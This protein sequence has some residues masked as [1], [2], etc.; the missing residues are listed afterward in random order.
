MNLPPS[1]FSIQQEI[2]TF[3]EING[4]YQKSIKKRQ[5][6]SDTLEKYV[7]ETL[8]SAGFPVSHSL[9]GIQVCNLCFGPEREPQMWLYHD[10]YPYAN[11]IG[12]GKFV[13][14]ENKNHREIYSNEIVD[15]ELPFDGEKILNLCEQLTEQ[16][17]ISV[18]FCE[19][20]VIDVVDEAREYRQLS[21]VH[22]TG[23]IIDS[24]EIEYK[25]WDCTDDWAVV[26]DVDGRHFYCGTSA[27]GGGYTYH[28]RP[29]EDYSVIKAFLQSDD[30]FVSEEVFSYFPE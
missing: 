26:D 22:K 3:F 10:S 29:G 24:G 18:R 28:I 25:G 7:K 16:L 12:N 17:G 1:K 9:S 21:L 20:K 14:T 15:M 2:K 6:L 5:E 4:M 11:Y 8:K 13:V 30:V 19:T 27:H 23:T